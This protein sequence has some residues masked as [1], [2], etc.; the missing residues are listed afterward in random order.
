MNRSKDTSRQSNA[1]SKQTYTGGIVV[2]TFEAGAFYLTNTNSFESER[3]LGRKSIDVRRTR[4]IRV[5]AN[6]AF[7]S[8]TKS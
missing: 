8:K 6:P 7:L 5:L 3:Y 2:Y 1:S 4:K